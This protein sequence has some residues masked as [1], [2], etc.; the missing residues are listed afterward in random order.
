MR[1]PILRKTVYWNKVT[2]EY[3]CEKATTSLRKVPTFV[4][5]TMTKQSVVREPL[6]YICL[7]TKKKIIQASSQLLAIIIIWS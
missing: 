4:A 2:Q 5:V 1:K 6:K 3:F 7:T